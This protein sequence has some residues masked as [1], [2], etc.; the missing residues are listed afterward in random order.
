MFGKSFKENTIMKY[1]ILA[2]FLVFGIISATARA[3][4]DFDGDGKT[5]ISVYRRPTGEWFYRS[6]MDGSWAS[7]QFGTATDTIA[8]ADYTG[9]GKDD[10]AFYRPSTGEWF[11]VRSENFSYYAFPFG[12]AED[13]P[14][15]ADYDG[16]GKADPAVY[17]PSM[18]RYF[19]LRSTG[20]VS[21]VPWG[22]VGDR[23]APAA[24]YDGDGKADF[25]VLEQCCS[26]KWR[27]LGSSAGPLYYE[28]N[29]GGSPIAGD[30]TGDGKADL[31]WFNSS[32]GEWRFRRSE[33]GVE[34][35]IQTG[36]PT[37]C[38]L[39][40]GDYD[41]DGKFDPGLRVVGQVQSN[42]QIRYSSDGAVVRYTFGLPDDRDQAIA[43]TFLNSCS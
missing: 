9:D 18:S 10:F 26:F 8:P 35:T 28:F 27:I 24:D 42:W 30:Y 39:A 6:S 41:G 17:R 4:F 21:Y 36:G 3:P 19:V 37:G 23:T 22:V 12:L 11:I 31:S 1:T 29:I 32:S 38:R 20:G 2:C 5:D 15:P 7:I 13:K 34:S 14:M 43:G 25:A 16:D 40:P 33:D